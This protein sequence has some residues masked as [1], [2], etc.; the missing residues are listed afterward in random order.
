MLAWLMENMA[1]VIVSVIL[2]LAVAAIII[3]MIRS[4]RKGK[5]SC[6]CG[7][8]GCPMG[9]SCHTKAQ[10]GRSKQAEHETGGGK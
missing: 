4:I 10:T 2:I 6:G 8:A 1:T 7:C 5:S 9:A 3:S